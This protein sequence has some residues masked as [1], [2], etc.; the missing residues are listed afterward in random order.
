MWFILCFIHIVFIM[1]SSN[2]RF[3]YR[4]LKDGVFFSPAWW[5]QRA[6]KN[7]TRPDASLERQLG[8]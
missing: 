5:Q 3:I 7:L 6:E 1:N 8:K 2:D 4:Q